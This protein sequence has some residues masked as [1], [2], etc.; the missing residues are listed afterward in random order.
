MKSK[1][2]SMTIKEAQEPKK[3][4]FYRLIKNRYWILDE[5]NCLLFY[6]KNLST[7][8]PQC[9]SNKTISESI[10]KGEKHPGVT[11]KLIENAFIPIDSSNF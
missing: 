2:W 11:I 9:N 1:F 3:E 8:S 6:G 4:D 10:L 5:N 7:G